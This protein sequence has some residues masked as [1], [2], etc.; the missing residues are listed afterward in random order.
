[1][2]LTD[3]QGMYITSEIESVWTFKYQTVIY[4]RDGSIT[5]IPTKRK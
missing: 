5:V 2:K 1:M 3:P 4:R